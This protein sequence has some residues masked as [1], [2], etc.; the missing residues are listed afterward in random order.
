MPEPPDL[1]TIELEPEVRTWL[2]GLPNA[3]YRA[4]ERFA[5]RLAAEGPHLPFP[6]ASHLGGGPREL[7]V[8]PVRVTYWLAPGRRAVLLTVFRKTRMRETDE[9]ERAMR[10]RKTCEAEHPPAEEHAVYSGPKEAAR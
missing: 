4:V 1:F 5:D 3:E 6:L 2:E 7:R 10:V 8:G 9:V